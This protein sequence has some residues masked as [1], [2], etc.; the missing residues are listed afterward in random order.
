MLTVKFDKKTRKAINVGQGQCTFCRE[1]GKVAKA[2]PQMWICARCFFE[3]EVGTE[4]MQQ[5]DKEGLSGRVLIRA[6]V[7]DL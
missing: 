4:S 2:N 3:T 1:F 5:A 7:E 6:C